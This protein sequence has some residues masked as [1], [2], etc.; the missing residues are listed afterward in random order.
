MIK[1]IYE[2]I[3]NKVNANLVLDQLFRKNGDRAREAKLGLLVI[4]EKK[5][6]MMFIAL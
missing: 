6:Q 2:R 3:Y 1:I 5:I 4:A